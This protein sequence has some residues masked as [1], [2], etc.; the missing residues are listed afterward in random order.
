MKLSLQTSVNVIRNL[1]AIG[2]I[3]DR[4]GLVANQDKLLCSE[5]RYDKDRKQLS[6][7]YKLYNAEMTQCGELIYYKNGGNYFHSYTC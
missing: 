5:V 3:Q 2:F 6:T 4:N 1:V 7:V